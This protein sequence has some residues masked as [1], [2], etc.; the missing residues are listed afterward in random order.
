MVKVGGGGQNWLPKMN[1]YLRSNEVTLN[2]AQE[3]RSNS[4]FILNDLWNKD[5]NLF[6]EVLKYCKMYRI[7]VI[8]LMNHRIEKGIELL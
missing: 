4:H 8:L 7:Y 6:D 5:F 3:I 1:L 2:L